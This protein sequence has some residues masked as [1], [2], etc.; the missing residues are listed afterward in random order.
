MRWL[1]D[2]ILL[3][4]FAFVLFVTG[5]LLSIWIGAACGWRWVRNYTF[6]VAHLV[7]ICL[8]AVEALLG[9]A[10]PLTVWENALRARPDETTFMARVLHG[11]LFYSFPEWIFTAAYVAFALLVAATWRWVRPRRR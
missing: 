10:C 8:V 5:G 7:A 4:H 11:L 2:L 1:A 6:R 9:M 3:V